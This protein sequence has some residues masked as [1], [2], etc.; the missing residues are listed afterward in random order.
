MAAQ[1]VGTAQVKLTLDTTDYDIA[2]DR[3]KQKQVGLGDVVASEAAKMTRAQRQV[4][5]SLDNQATKLGL[6]REQWLQ[7]KIITQTSGDVQ[8]ALLAKVKANTVAITQQGNAAEKTGI[9]FN[10]YGLSVKQEAAALRQVPA[11]M[12]DIFVSL[13]GGQNPLTVLLQQGGQL[14]D[15]FGGVMPAVRALGGALLGL[16]NPLTIV[17]GGI[18]ALGFAAVAHAQ[19]MDEFNL[20]VAKSGGYAVQSVGDVMR[21]RDAIDSLGGVSSGMANEVVNRVVSGGQISAAL[22]DKVSAAA[23]SWASVTGQS[24]DDVV[25]KYERLAKDPLTAINELNNAEHFLS[26]EQQQRIATLQEEGQW[27]EAATLALN[28]YADTHLQRAGDVEGTLSNW[29]RL[30]RSLKNDTSSAWQEMKGFADWSLGVSMSISANNAKLLGGLF[31]NKANTLKD[32]WNAV[33]GWGKGVHGS[34]YGQPVPQTDAKTNS[35]ATATANMETAKLTAERLA[36]EKRNVSDEDKLLKEKERIQKV[37]TELALGAKWIADQ[38]A[39]AEAAAAKKNKGGAG[40]ARSLANAGASAEL[41]AIQDQE[42][43]QR[44]EIANT[45]KVLNAEYNARLITQTDYYTKQRELV[46]RDQAAQE[47]SLTKQI[48]FLRGRDV[49]GKDSINVSK[50]LGELEAKLAKVRADGATQLV[51]LG[52]QEKDVA[53]KRQRAIDGYKLSLATSN[54]VAKKTADAAVARIMLGQREAEQQEK[55]SA[56]LADSAEKQRQLNKEYAENNDLKM[57][58]EKLAALQAYTDEQVRIVKDGFDRL[59]AAQGD[60]L[61]GFSSGI[62]DWMAGASNVA[63]QTNRIIQNSLDKTVDALTEFATTG[64]FQWKSLLADILTEITRFLMKQAVLQFVQMFASMWMGGGG[65]AYTGPSTAGGDYGAFNP[66]PNAKGNAYAS[67]DLSRYSGTVVS[68][69]TPFYFAKGAGVMGEAGHEGIFPLQRGSDGKLGVK[70]SGGM[71]GDVYINTTV[72][73]NGDNTSRDGGSTGGQAAM[74][75]EL[76]EMVTAG[77]ERVVTRALQPGGQIWKARGGN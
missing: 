62:N 34:L 52:I 69:P 72:N 20:S 68:N 30:W 48:A 67:A 10:K 45:T 74:Y 7:Y 9:Q 49:A 58:N 63:G 31:G 59:D 2:V 19:D 5:Q 64:K 16:V 27:Q 71:T 23:A 56:V 70:A 29:A 36:I 76:S 4:I 43:M 66:T 22:L 39:A 47:E 37:G 54:E 17:L 46:T 51:I 8:N 65:G 40:A 3:S 21:L 13:Q 57:Y 73:V 77:A 24:I 1:D 44:A 35:A 6:T 53:E 32:D 42:T 41:Q 60:W 50:Q 38:T 11:Q 26:I 28:I 18:G 15:V 75:R 14:K 12:T 55:L 25:G 61:N 33:V